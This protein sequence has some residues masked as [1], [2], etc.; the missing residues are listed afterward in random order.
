MAQLS[1]FIGALK[2]GGAR[3]NQFEVT[4]TSGPPVISQLSK[5]FRFLCRATTVPALS[6]GEVAVPYRGKQI[7]VSGERTYEPWTITVFSD[8]D[9]VMRHVF[10]TWQSYLHD[11]G[12]TTERETIGEQ[13]SRYYGQAVVKQMDRNDGVLRTYN[14]YDVWPTSVDAEEF[15]F[16]TNDSIMEFGVTFRFNYMTVTGVG[17]SAGVLGTP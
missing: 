10:E 17:S 7:F 12:S 1:N 11:I 8:R 13:P 15:N 2:E 16:E 6:I 4:I 9:L 14:L 3:P 5:D